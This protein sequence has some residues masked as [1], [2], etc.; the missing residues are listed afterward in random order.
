MQRVS[1]GQRR[2]IAAGRLLLSPARFVIADEPAAHLDAVGAAA[3]MVLPEPDLA[4]LGEAIQRA[5]ASGAQQHSSVQPGEEGGHPVGVEALEPALAQVFAR[6]PAQVAISAAS[7]A[8]H[9]RLEGRS[10]P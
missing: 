9:E 4:R 2:R 5:E 8:R 1:G 7:H 3:L 10:P 6:D